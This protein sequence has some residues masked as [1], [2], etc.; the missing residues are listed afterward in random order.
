MTSTQVGRRCGSLRVGC[1]VSE[2]GDLRGRQ[3]SHSP[4]NHSILPQQ[5]TDTQTSR[6]VSELTGLALANYT[7]FTGRSTLR[8][9][10]NS[11]RLA[12]HF[13]GP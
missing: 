4:D 1:G 7:F 11:W 3:R 12:D 8:R 9:L 10:P 2:P 5:T 13:T 6:C